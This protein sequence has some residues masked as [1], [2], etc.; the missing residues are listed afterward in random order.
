MEGI[1]II[2]RKWETFIYLNC[3]MNKSVFTQ[4]PNQHNMGLRSQVGEALKVRRLGYDTLVIYLAAT[5]L[6][7]LC[8]ITVEKVNPRSKVMD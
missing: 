2:C 5:Y 4:F 1:K 3:E 8:E 7:L 6:F